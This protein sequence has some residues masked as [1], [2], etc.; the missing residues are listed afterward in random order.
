M[1]T[2]AYKPMILSLNALSLTYKTSYNICCHSGSV[3]FETKALACQNGN[4][5]AAVIYNKYEGLLKSWLARENSQVTIPVIGVSRV[6]G[7]TLLQ[8]AN[9][10]NSGGKGEINNVASLSTKPGYKYMQGT[11]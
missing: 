2:I 11:R 3:T 1:C 10:L 4:G 7:L 9:T 5:V 6:V 8:G